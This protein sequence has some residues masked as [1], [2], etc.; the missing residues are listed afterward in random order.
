MI[1]KQASVD[2]SKLKTEFTLYSKNG[3]PLMKV[4]N[5]YTED[6]KVKQN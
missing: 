5:K 6:F 1:I 3:T 4:T 2:I